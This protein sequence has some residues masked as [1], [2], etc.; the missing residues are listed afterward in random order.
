MLHTEDDSAIL[1]ITK[2]F[3]RRESNGSGVEFEVVSVL[4]VKEALILLRRE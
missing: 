1:E 3:L 4:S 2:I